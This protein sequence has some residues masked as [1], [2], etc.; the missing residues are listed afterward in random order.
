MPLSEP[1]PDHAAVGAGPCR[2]RSRTMPLSERDP[3]HAAA[4]TRVAEVRRPTPLLP[5]CPS[6]EAA[7]LGRVFAVC[8]KIKRE[9]AVQGG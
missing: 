9:I 3:D 7:L 8:V 2:C 1:D 5:P 4:R 6:S